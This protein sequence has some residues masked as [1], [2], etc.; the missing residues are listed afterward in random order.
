MDGESEENLALIPS[1]HAQ[2][3]VTT[4]RVSSLEILPFTSRRLGSDQGQERYFMALDAFCNHPAMQ[5]L[6][7]R[8]NMIDSTESFTGSLVSY[9]SVGYVY[10]A[11][12]PLFGDLVKIGATMR[13]K[14]FIRVLELSRTGVPEPFH[15]VSSIPSKNPFALEREIHEHFRLVR[16]YGRKKEFFV[17][18]VAEV[19][20]YFHF[21]SLT[22]M[23]PVS[24][25]TDSVKRK[26]TRSKVSKVPVQAMDAPSV[27][28]L[29]ESAQ[30]ECSSKGRS[31]K[32]LITYESACKSITAE[33]CMETGGFIFDEC[34]TIC[35]QSVKYTL[36]HSQC[37]MLRSSITVLIGYL[38][39]Q[40]G[41]K[42]SNAFGYDC[43]TMGDEVK[44]HPG[45]ALMI[46]EVKNE[47]PNLEAWLANG[48]MR[49]IRR[50]LLYTH[51]SG[52]TDSEMT[53]GQLIQEMK[54]LRQEH[55]DLKLKA[56]ESE[57]LSLQIQE[58]REEGEILR[59]T[60]AAREQILTQAGM[61][62][63]IQP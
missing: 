50:G 59:K 55:E 18:S 5:I 37:R 35:V 31:R 47:N 53:R 34:Y 57:L 54:K 26:R 28:D 33:M 45:M 19:V 62:N 60:L 27:E 49:E 38:Q 2:L 12:N 41:I 44:S 24:G 48:T 1:S 4:P 13:S 7:E 6:F 25:S 46:A 30:D 36:L 52:F 22:P 40:H 42:M 8:V 16:K 11:W 15:L 9:E 10:A 14:P 29:G 21:R 20:D 61:Q 58:L 39:V 23:A 3:A 32:C 56:A 17:L 43:V 63:L 51:L